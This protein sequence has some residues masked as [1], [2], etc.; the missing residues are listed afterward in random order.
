VYTLEHNNPVMV[1]F[2]DAWHWDLGLTTKIPIELDSS[3]G[4]GSL[5]LLLDQMQLEKLHVGQ[6]VGEVEVILPDGDYRAEFEQAIGQV[7]V[8]VPRDVP[9]R[10]SV[11]RAIS[12]LSVPSDFEKYNNFYYSPGARGADEFIHI[13]INQA[14]GSIAVRYER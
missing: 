12:S 11:S 14:I 8:E 4:V 9:I 1:P 6:G 2:E 5:G 13:E 3:M 10:L 7:I